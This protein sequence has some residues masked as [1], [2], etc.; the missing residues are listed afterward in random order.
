MAD[1]YGNTLSEAILLL[2]KVSDKL[3]DKTLKKKE[4]KQDTIQKVANVKDDVVDKNKKTNEN[5][6][7][8][9]AMQQASIEENKEKQ[10]KED[11]PKEVVD[12]PKEVI[13]A[14]F[15]R[16][17]TKELS[18]FLKHED[19]HDDKKPEDNKDKGKS[20]LSKLLGPGVL[21]VLGV[22][23]G[24]GGL[25]SSVIKG[26]FGKL[27]ND[28]K[29]GNFKAIGTDLFKIAYA[30]LQPKLHSL[31]IIGPILSIWDAYTAFQS[32]NAIGGINNLIQGIVG[33]FPLPNDTK[34]KIF[35]GMNIVEALMER[36]FGTETIPKNVGGNVL[37]AML[38]SSK[39]VFASLLKMGG[40]TGKITSQVLKS[41]PLLKKLPLIGSLL[42]F[43]AAGEFFFSGSKTASGWV[44]A[45]LNIA[46][47]IS[48]FF[49]GVGTAISLGLDVIN[50]LLFTTKTNDKGEEEVTTRDWI[51]DFGS[52]A[53]DTYRKAMVGLKNMLPGFM[54]DLI[55]INEDGS[56]EITP[57]KMIS[58]WMEALE[59]A[60][61]PFQKVA[62]TKAVT[63]VSKEEETRRKVDEARKRMVEKAGL[64]LQNE[65]KL[66][67]SDSA[68][69]QGEVTDQADFNDLVNSLPNK[70]TPVKD[71]IRT[72]DGKLI[73][74]SDN[75]TTFGF[76]PGG[77]L[78]KYF[79]KNFELTTENNT[80]LK[81]LTKATN[82][83]L[84]KQIDIL[85]SSNRHLAEMK[86]N[87]NTPSNIITAPRIT[88]NTYG[89]LGSLRA[90]QG[91]T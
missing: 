38:K 85:Q 25:I 33:L 31:P 58:D 55:T 22:I 26:D 75:D 78:D 49:P 48:A 62:P 7:K 88:N 5:L 66:T 17:A 56:V 40:T 82:D 46:S 77:S 30:T 72:P 34:A 68:I 43:G 83:L 28:L 37:S 18:M 60:L 10:E 44:Q 15:G 71:F 73:Q 36:K 13:I 57:F 70:Q 79:N 32:G 89:G 9:I 41:N 6:E 21:T 20:W 63:V 47:G 11:K 35:G 29:K 3:A 8:L 27:F 1:T 65:S 24:L 4:G 80:I 59:N 52:W 50:T 54:S 86:N 61:D 87:L 14:G 23:A 64:M 45:I 12:E 51:G 90:L 74:P 53:K 2:S 76:Q 81:N 16:K 67:G 69:T 39:L 42:S 91:V 84:Q 19:D